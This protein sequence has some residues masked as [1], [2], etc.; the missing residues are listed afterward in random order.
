MDREF[1]RSTY[2]GSDGEDF[3]KDFAEYLRFIVNNRSWFAMSDHSLYLQGAK[4]AILEIIDELAQGD[5]D[6]KD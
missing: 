6:G 2:M 5:H 3:R 1:L 4:Q